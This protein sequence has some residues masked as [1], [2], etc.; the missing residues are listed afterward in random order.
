MNV[1][2]FSVTELSVLHVVA[3]L[4]IPIKF[5]PVDRVALP[6]TKLRDGRF[7]QQGFDLPGCR[8]QVDART[9]PRIS[10]EKP[11]VVTDRAAR[12]TGNRF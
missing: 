1:P 5:Q 9:G 12:R 4:H 6:G 8:A 11:I 10:S 7:S 2:S 3:A